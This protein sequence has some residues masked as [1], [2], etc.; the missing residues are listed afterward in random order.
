[1]RK[2]YEQWVRRTWH[3]SYRAGLIRNKH[4]AYMMFDIQMSWFAWAAGWRVSK[5]RGV[6]K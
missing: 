1:M 4:G 6:A 5:N 3:K 2:S